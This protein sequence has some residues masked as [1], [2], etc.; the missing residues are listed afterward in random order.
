LAM[1]AMAQVM[2]SSQ[3]AS[4]SFLAKKEPKKLLLI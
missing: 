1:T 2:K 4:S 3:T